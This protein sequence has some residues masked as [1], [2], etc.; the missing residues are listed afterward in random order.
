MTKID[1]VIKMSAEFK[2]GAARLLKQCKFRLRSLRQTGED[3]EIEV[4]VINPFNFVVHVELR[5]NRNNQIMYYHC[6][7]SGA[8]CGDFFCDHCLAAA[9][10]LDR[11]HGIKINYSY[12]DPDKK[13][14]PAPEKEKEAVPEYEDQPA[15]LWGAEAAEDDKDNNGVHFTDFNEDDPAQDGFSTFEPDFSEEVKNDPLFPALTEEEEMPPENYMTADYGSGDE[16]MS[17]DGFGDYPVSEYDGMS[18]LLGT[19]TENGEELRL[20]PNDT[21]V[22]MHNNIGVIGTMGTGKTQFIKSLITQI[23][24]HQSHNFGGSPVGIMI[25][26]YKGDYNH[27]KPEFVRATGAFV[28]KA[29]KISYNPFALSLKENSVP[30]L[31]LHTANG[32]TDTLSRIYGLGPKQAMLLRDCIMEAYERRGIK[33]ADE[34]TWKF[35][36]PTFS[37][38]YRIYEERKPSSVNDSLTAVMSKLDSFEIFESDGRKTVPFSRLMD[39]VIV[40]DLSAYDE[41]IQNLVIAITLDQFYTTMQSLGSSRTDGRFRQLR[42]FILVDEADNFMKKGFPSLKKIMKEGREFGVGVILSTQ[43]L[44]HFSGSSDD[45]SRYILTWVVHNVSDLNRSD[46]EYIL[47]QPKKSTESEEIYFAVKNLEKHHS[48]V[49]IAN[50]DPTVIEDKPFWQLCQEING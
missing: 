16:P 21:S 7:G 38:V 34:S 48:V 25:F 12:D 47:K 3:K 31:P 30:L 37:D 33:K 4:K 45:Y 26:D 22:M 11:E 17:G 42:N 19:Q 1:V 49:K 6:D 40:F 35:A 28:T 46:V 39:K 29:Y 32:F 8:D 27:T 15:V 20:Y 10:Y 14:A 36:P 44:S 9:G 5:L 24:L 18:I 13:E 43:S 50:N 41:D 23:R 2:D